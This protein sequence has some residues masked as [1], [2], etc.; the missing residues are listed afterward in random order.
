MEE[1]VVD[2]G[3][4]QG[5][6]AGGK[7]AAGKLR[8]IQIVDAKDCPW[9]RPAGEQ[10]AI[11]SASRAGFSHSRRRPLQHQLAVHEVPVQGLADL[12]TQRGLPGVQTAEGD[13]T[14]HQC[15]K[16]QKNRRRSQKT[17]QNSLRIVHASS[18]L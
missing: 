13:H 5:E 14:R 10:A 15:P 9:S 12:C 1:V 11:R 2:S 16:G 3:A 4:G 6:I 18:S 7:G 8:P 17:V